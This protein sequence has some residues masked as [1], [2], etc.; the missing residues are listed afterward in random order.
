M[1]LGT[2]AAGM[3][4]CAGRSKCISGFSSACCEDVLHADMPGVVQFWKDAQT[5]EDDDESGLG[6]S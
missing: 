1:T 5:V 6:P 3:I 4:R 2:K